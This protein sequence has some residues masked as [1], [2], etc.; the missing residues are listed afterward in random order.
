MPYIRQVDR[1]PI[2]SAIDALIGQLKAN[3]ATPGMLNYT[4]T[5]ILTG[6][7]IPEDGLRYA[8]INNMIGVLGCVS[9]ELYRRLGAPYENQACYTH[10]D[11]PGLDQN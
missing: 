11:V 4:I 3:N 5:R 2:D 9:H 8:N 10:G 1:D 7:A 6:V